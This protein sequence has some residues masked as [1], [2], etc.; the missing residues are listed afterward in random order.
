MPIIDEY[1]DKFEGTAKTKLLK[2]R[3]VIK[4]HAPGAEECFAYGI[5][6]FK[7]NGNLVHF[8][9]YKNHIGFYPAPSGIKAFAKQLS[10]YEHSKGAVKFLLSE[11]LP[12]K[13]IADIVKF[14]V[15]ENTA[16]SS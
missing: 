3:D 9:G 15:N 14:R 8:A 10:G 16:K 1:I 11:K 12:I 4:K 7:L 13:L 2:M 6:T 5:P